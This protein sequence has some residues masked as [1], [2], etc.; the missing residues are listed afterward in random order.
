VTVAEAEDLRRT[1]RREVVDRLL[2]CCPHLPEQERV[3]IVSVFGAGQS[4]T[5]LAGLLR[6][7]PRVTRR[8]VRRI[9]RRAMSP[10]FSYVA[11]RS[12][13]WPATRRAVARAC[14]L[15]GLSMREAAA[16]TGATL[17]AVRRHCLAVRAMLEVES[18]LRRAG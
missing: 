8:R 2:E 5:D 9:I 11:R 18:S 6:E 14:Y 4:A 13:A 17:H 7:D 12:E 3:L 16:R 1:H 15:Q 10:M